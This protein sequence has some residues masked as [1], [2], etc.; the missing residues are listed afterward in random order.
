M[1]RAVIQRQPGPAARPAEASGPVGPTQTGTA[2]A[3]APAVGVPATTPPRPLPGMVGNVGYY[4][5][6]HADFI[7]RHPTAPPSPPDYYMSY[8]DKY[9]RRFTTVLRPTLSAAGQGW[10]D[11]TFVLLQ[12]AIENRLTA[13][14][15]AFDALERDGARFRAFAYATHPRAYL[16]GGLHSLPATDLARIGSTPDLGDLTTIDG[17]KQVLETGVE[18]VPQWGGD[19]VDSAVSTA[20]SAWG[21]LSN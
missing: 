15:V 19:A 9:A 6:R 2:T 7:A 20:Q 11:R 8:G 18:L 14:P 10:V 5:A 12:Q 16:D 4:A 13:D 3:T 1:S 17:V 21:W